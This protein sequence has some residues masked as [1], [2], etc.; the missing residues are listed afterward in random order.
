MSYGQGKEMLIEQIAGKKIVRE[1]FN[2]NGDL[3]GKQL[4]IIGELIQE[5]ETYKVEVVTELYDANGELDEKYT[6]SYKCN[7][8][9]FNVLLNV[10]PFADPQDKKIKVDV[11]S[12]DFKQLYDL[13][14]GSELKDI[15][16]KMSVESGVL[17]FFGS[18]SLV[19]IKNRE[20]E[21]VNESVKI[22]SEAVIRVFLLGLRIKTITYSVQESMTEK[23]V[24]QH[25][26][27]IEED[28][29]YF[30]MNYGGEY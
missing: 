23:F 16:L 28:G 10:F 8:N 22:S 21:V 13:Q 14:S 2:K 11:T 25:Q 26:K 3:Q 19:T 24:L 1:N 9:Q 6:T 15:H 5:G 30:T 29:A 12:E 4:F 20:K 7:P 17:S 27:F 18:K